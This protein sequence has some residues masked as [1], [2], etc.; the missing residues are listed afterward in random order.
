MDSLTG[1]VSYVNNNHYIPYLFTNLEW[2]KYDCRN[3]PIYTTK[4]EQ[5]EPCNLVAEKI[6]CICDTVSAILEMQIS[7]IISNLNVTRE[8]YNIKWSLQ[9]CS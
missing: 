9:Y 8:R 5:I 7:L 2:I 6:C 4:E 1:V 3:R